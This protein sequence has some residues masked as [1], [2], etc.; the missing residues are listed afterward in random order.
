MEVKVP[1]KQPDLLPIM[2]LTPTVSLPISTLS[3][4]PLPLFIQSYYCGGSV[5]FCPVGMG[6]GMG[7]FPSYSTPLFQ[8]GFLAFSVLV[9][10]VLVSLDFCFF[11][12]TDDGV[13]NP[14]HLPFSFF[15]PAARKGV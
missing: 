8:S 10:W 15:L 13:K 1:P 12:K 5:Q 11:E 2:Q 4:H 14:G 7:T 9:S 3:T 6:M